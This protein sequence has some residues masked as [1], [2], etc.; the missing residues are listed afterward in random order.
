M[1]FSGGKAPG[2]AEGLE[3]FAAGIDAI[4]EEAQ[5]RVALNYFEDGS[6]ESA[7]PPLKA[8]LHIMAQG[9]YQGMGLEDP[10]FL[11][12]LFERE[13]VLSLIG[14]D[15]QPLQTG[16]RHRV[17]APLVSPRTISEFRN[18]AD[19]SHAA[20]RVQD[21]VRAAQ[22]QLARV[23]T[24][25]YLGELRGTIGADPFTGQTAR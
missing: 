20:F 7:C 4:V 6:V 23:S 3:L 21:R 10:K 17:V 5:R 1:V 22:E 12:A 9:E 14:I 8:L 16:A 11:R 19:A 24:P 13:V 15:G 25:A 2:K 18:G